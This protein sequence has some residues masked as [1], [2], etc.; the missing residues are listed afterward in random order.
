[1]LAACWVGRVLVK[2]V[3]GSQLPE[4]RQGPAARVAPEPP[5]RG[6]QWGP[7]EGTGFV[8]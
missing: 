5:G 2:E 1:M 6:H 4:L 3:G 7:L 8:S